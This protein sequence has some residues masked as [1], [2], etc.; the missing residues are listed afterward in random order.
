MNVRGVIIDTDCALGPPG[1]KVDDGFA[2]ALAVASP[3][4]EVHLV[5]TTAGNV[6]VL[7]A[8]GRTGSLLERLGRDIPVAAGGPPDGGAAATE[9]TARALREPG[10]L[11][12]I[13]LGPLTNVAAALAADPGV[14]G[15]LAEVVVMGGRFLGPDDASS[16]FNVRND[17]WATRAVLDSGVRVRLVGLDVT[18]RLA[19][20]PAEL[21]RLARGG[22]LARH[23][24]ALARARL[25]ALA[26]EGVTACPMHD[27]LAVLAVTHPELITFEAATLEVALGPGPGRGRTSARLHPADPTATT[28]V[29]VDVDARRARETLIERLAALP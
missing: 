5:T 8:T 23:L 22:A 28:L 1:A 25:A 16:E 4:L 13:A 29:A 7:T 26:G 27:P 9:I 14:A 18:P 11:T 15:A 19:L 3:E 17:P 20:G 12:V 2:L 21:D 24:A 10:G 6:D